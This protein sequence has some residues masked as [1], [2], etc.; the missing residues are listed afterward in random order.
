MP[1][2]WI[3]ARDKYQYPK[4]GPIDLTTF[5][6]AHK[7]QDQGWFK[8]SF[9]GDLRSTREFQ[10]RFKENAPYHLKAWYEVVYW[11]YYSQKGIRNRGTRRIIQN[12]RDSDITAS[13]LFELCQNYV[14]SGDLKD[15]EAFLYKIASPDSLAVA[16]TFPAFIK[17][18]KFPMVD[19][20]I[21][22]WAKK[23]GHLHSYAPCGGPVLAEAPVLRQGG[24]NNLRYN[25]R[26]HRK[27]AD[28]W[29]R[30][31]R[32]TAGKLTEL[33]GCVWSPRD[34]EMAV[35]T[36]QRTGRTLNPL[37]DK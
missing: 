29:I 5:E 31:C 20:E 34:V 27:F 32:F 12:I 6:D 24:V 13:C 25:L 11:K 8:C 36:A 35:F 21:T 15:F 14:D 10:A 3:E 17:P 2:S 26:K 33:T 18:E 9:D 7:Y 1:D 37:T 28:S 4:S 22:N 30:W 16:A 23:N 19:R